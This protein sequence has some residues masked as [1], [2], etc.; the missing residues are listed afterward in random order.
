MKRSRALVLALAVVATPSIAQ[1]V[2][3]DYDH[4]FDFSSVKTVAYVATEDSNVRD[5]LTDERI[6]SAIV[7]ELKEG[8]LE[9]VDSDA[10]LYI[11]YH[12]TTEDNTVLNTSGR[13]VRS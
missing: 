6:K 12:V 8:G 5:Q 13:E 1:D 3:I 11:T 4:D 2:T 9:P 7:S 10:D